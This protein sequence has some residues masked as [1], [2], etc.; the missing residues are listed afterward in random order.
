MVSPVSVLI[1][2]DAQSVE[3]P[4]KSNHTGR[5]EK[6]A[7]KGG[8]RMSTVSIIRTG[9]IFCATLFPVFAVTAEEEGQTEIDG[10]RPPD[11]PV[12]SGE[13]MYR[14][15][16]AVCHALDGKGGGPATP[17]LRDQVPD[18]TTL[19]QRH[20]G[21]YPA[22]YV[23][24]ILRFGTAKGFPAHGNKDMPIWGRVFASVPET[25]ESTVT[26]RITSLTEYLGTIQAK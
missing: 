20:G 3:V 10:A 24:S 26:R 12:K 7:M 23:E 17:A 16:C 15:Y 11:A 6:S 9:A 19:S 2:V 14:S 21:K 1:S 22:Q 4:D 25:A 18:L 13:E 8:I 5:V